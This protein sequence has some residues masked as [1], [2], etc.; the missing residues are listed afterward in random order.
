MATTRYRSA[1]K[2]LR[3]AGHR[4]AE[5]G[6]N[7]VKSG[8]EYLHRAGVEVG[9]VE[10]AT[11]NRRRDREALV[12]RARRGTVDRNHCP[13]GRDGRVPAEDRAAL[14]R[15]DESGGTRGATVSHDKAGAQNQRCRHNAQ[16]RGFTGAHHVRRVGDN[17]EAHAL[18]GLLQRIR[19]LQP[20]CDRRNFPCAFVPHG[21]E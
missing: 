19:H 9:R 12:H 18:L 4:I 16:Q 1:R 3:R 17:A 20:T 6:R 14:G 21:F 2:C 11:R 7:G 10:A 5:P 15:E 13:V 8:V